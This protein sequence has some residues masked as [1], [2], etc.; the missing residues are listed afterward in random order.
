MS[1]VINLILATGL[2][3]VPGHDAR[4]EALGFV[5]V[6]QHAGGNKVMERNVWLAAFNHLDLEALA[7]QLGAIE[8]EWPESVQLL[9]R[10]QHGARFD[11]YALAI[12]F[13]DGDCG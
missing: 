10:D 13:E 12:P 5:R 6:D 3:E 4:L 2:E 7:A 1:H 8:W 11:E 9:V